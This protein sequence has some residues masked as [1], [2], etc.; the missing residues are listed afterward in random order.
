MALAAERAI[1]FDAFAPWRAGYDTPEGRQRMDGDHRVAGFLLAANAAQFMTVIMLG[2]S[3]APGYP[4]RT[5]AI[6]DLGVTPETA[7]LFNASLVMV[8]LLNVV[9]G[10]LLYRV[11]GRRWLLA[12]FLVAGI[13]AAGAGLVPLN[14]G[15]LH[16]VFALVAFVAFNVQAIGSG[17]VLRGPMRQISFAAGLAGLVFVVLM[18]VGDAGNQAAFGPIGH[19]GTE[20]M[21]VYPVMLWLTAF[22]GY[23]I[24][25][26]QTA[27]A[28]S[29]G[30]P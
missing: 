10:Y 21:I 18:V 23:L 28:H 19:G 3:I 9:G 16:G 29:D 11:H 17:A 4:Y 12:L 24:A 26:G 13:G 2:A 6:S 30:R 20:R 15:A 1:A 5:G 7:V 22:G 14:R 27:E 25:G 8:G